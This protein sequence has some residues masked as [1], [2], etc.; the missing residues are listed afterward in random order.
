MSFL[1]NKAPHALPSGS[2]CALPPQSTSFIITAFPL[3]QH[4]HMRQCEAVLLLLIRV[5]SSHMLLV[6]KAGTTLALLPL[7]VSSKNGHF[8]FFTGQALSVH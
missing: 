5:I 2:L 8:G 6:G 4:L 7:V 3:P 1:L